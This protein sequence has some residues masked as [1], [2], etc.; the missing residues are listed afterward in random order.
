MASKHILSLDSCLVS[1]TELLHVKDTSQYAPNLEVDCA[2]LLITAPGFKTALI[3]TK[4][5]FDLK[6]TACSLNIQTTA[7]DSE[8]TE[9]PD[10]IYIIRY[11][12]SPN[13]KVYVEYNLLRTTKLM[14]LYYD[15]MCSIDVSP[16]EPSSDKKKLMDDM[17][18]IRTYIDAA[19]SKVEYCGSPDQGME[20][21]E[22]AKRKLEK[23]TC[24][25]C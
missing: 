17:A 21:Y 4:Q 10:G 22:F 2:E 8:R 16:C 20:L 3:S 6:I 1:N 23:I 11:S 19:K 9:L 5:G 24:N 15:K 25:V 12:V 7:C 14:E 13:N 18:L